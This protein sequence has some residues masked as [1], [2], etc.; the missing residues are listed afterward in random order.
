MLNGPVH[1]ERPDYIDF[2]LTV[3]PLP[4]LTLGF[5]GYYKFAANYVDEGQFGAPVLL[6][7]FNYA[8]A[9]VKGFEFLANYDYGPWS[10]YTNLAWSRAS[11]IGLNSGQFN[12]SQ[13]ELDYIAV[14]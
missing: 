2:G 4:H 13:A 5:S 11:V 1:A 12:A 3:K 9:Q 7:A 8:Y 6:T 14:N 10:L